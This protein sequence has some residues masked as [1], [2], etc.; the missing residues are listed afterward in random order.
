MQNRKIHFIRNY[1]YVSIVVIG[2]LIIILMA[3][4]IPGVLPDTKDSAETTHS[5]PTP[6]SEHTIDST[7]TNFGV[8]TLPEP[9]FEP[10]EPIEISLPPIIDTGALDN[11]L[12]PY[13]D[14]Y[15]VYYENLE[16]GFVYEMNADWILPAAS[17]IKAPYVLYVYTL[18]EA[19]LADLSSEHIYKSGDYKDG[20]GK[21]KDMPYGSV[22]TE[23]ELLQYAIRNSDNIAQTMLVRKYGTNEFREFAESLGANP[24]LITTVAGANMT[25]FEASIYAKAIYDYIESDSVYGETLKTDLMNTRNIMIVSDYP[26]A[27]KYGWWGVAFHD[28]AIVYADSPYIL[29]IFSDTGENINFTP[30]ANIS[31]RFQEFND[32]EFHNEF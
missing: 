9:P 31:R 30:F 10:P 18:A 20:S 28:M 14:R 8:I 3:V 11:F 17:V 24:A 15:A 32:N 13:T 6:P 16:T 21:I 19:G 22:F 12:S 4:I 2:A 29:V 25:A 26:V 5:E 27:R 23:Y 1:I 7:D